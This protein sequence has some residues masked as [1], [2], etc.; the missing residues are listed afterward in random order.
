MSGCTCERCADLCRRNPGWMTPTEARG[1]IAAGYGPRLMC[2]WLEPSEELGNNDRIH[3]LAPA[4]VGCEG[5]YAPE[6]DIWELMIGPP[7]KGKCI[8]FKTGLCEIHESGFKPLQCREAL[9]CGEKVGID[10]YEM[11]RLWN[12]DDGRELVDFWWKS[13]D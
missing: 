1:A 13:I 8:F 2:D 9:A 5:W 11:A 7:N 10:N 4:S 12:S 3:V 6:F